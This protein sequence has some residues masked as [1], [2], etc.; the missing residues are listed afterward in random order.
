MTRGWRTGLLAVAAAALLAGPACHR[1]EGERE[2]GRA[3]SQAG[4]TG[5]AER[6]RARGSRTVDGWVVRAGNQEVVIRRGAGD[7]PDLRLQVG[8]RTTVTIRGRRRPAGDLQEG[9]RVRASYDPSGPLPQ[10]VRI[11]AIGRRRR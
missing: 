7:A 6:G 8:P 1:H 2:G 11:E 4:S 9:T 5:A 3:A 10:A